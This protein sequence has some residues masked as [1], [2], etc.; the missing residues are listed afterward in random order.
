MRVLFTKSDLCGSKL[1]RWALEEPV[2][3]VALEH[4]GVV[5]HST[6][7]SVDL[8]ALGTFL[9]HREIIYTID[10][11]DY[12]LADMIELANRYEGSSYDFTGLVYFSVAALLR[13]FLN[14]PLPK[15]NTWNTPGQFLCTEVA[16]LLIYGYEDAIMTPYE[17]YLRLKST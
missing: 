3:H 4:D 17:M 14:V 1:I 11:P 13:K 7:G 15:S 5:L 6:W 10:V 2:S 9:E 16:S 8:D 12:G